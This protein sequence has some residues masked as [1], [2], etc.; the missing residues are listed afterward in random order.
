MGA[1]LGLASRSLS[2]RPQL[3][4]CEQ[5][6][7]A[8]LEMRRNSGG[9]RRASLEGAC[10]R[11]RGRTGWLK[12]L[13]F[14]VYGSLCTLQEVETVPAIVH[15][16]VCRRDPRL[17]LCITR[18]VAGWLPSKV[19]CCV[20]C[21]LCVCQGKMCQALLR[22]H[23]S[24]CMGQDVDGLQPKMAF[25]SPKLIYMPLHLFSIGYL[26][27]ARLWARQQGFK[28]K[29]GNDGKPVIKQITDERNG[30]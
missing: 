27:N 14:N 18:C 7:L 25:E 10:G 3:D 15:V 4:S 12:R 21:A 17:C 11:A 16:C 30:S 19:H 20:A 23:V 1:K 29:Q 13:L 28:D 8:L 22:N 2:T 6:I 9:E 26:Q 5:G 24:A